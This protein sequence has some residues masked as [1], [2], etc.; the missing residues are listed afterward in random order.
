M[1]GMHYNNLALSFQNYNIL[2]CCEAVSLPENLFVPDSFAV[3]I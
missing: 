3:N 1:N 2:F